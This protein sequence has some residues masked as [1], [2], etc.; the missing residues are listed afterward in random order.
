MAPNSWRQWANLT[1]RQLRQLGRVIDKEINSAVGRH[2]PGI[3]GR[4]V[5]APVPVPV[6]QT[7]PKF[8]VNVS[9]LSI[10]GYPQGAHEFVHFRG[11]QVGFGIAKSIPRVTMFSSAPRVPPRVPRGLFTNWNLNIGN[12]GQRMYST[13]S[14]KFTH[15]TVKNMA[16][17]L[18]CFFNSLDG[19]VP[20]KTEEHL[21]GVLAQSEC[22]KPRLSAKDVSLIRDMQLF[23]MIQHHKSEVHLTEGEGTVGAYVEFKT[24]QLEVN[25][26]IP[27][28][29]FANSLALDIWRDEIWNYTN[30]LKVLERNVRR[31]YENYGSLPITKTRDSIRVHFP[32]LTMLETDTLMTELEITM[33][34]VYPDPQGP[35]SDI[36]SNLDVNSDSEFSSV[37]S[38]SVSNETYGII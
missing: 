4:L 19:L 15:E 21:S 17:S 33:G 32:T 36:L 31:I 14:V 8:R 20:P 35:Q 23:D 7:P 16:M 11:G 29:M 27:Q 13:A 10:R 26:S 18:R 30:E 28:K 37:L 9:A 38:P 22:Y 12:S 3:T 34:T 6:R 25:K 1:K 5:K 2:L 24:P